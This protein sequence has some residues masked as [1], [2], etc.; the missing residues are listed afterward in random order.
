MGL[1][2]KIHPNSGQQFRLV[3]FSMMPVAREGIR[4]LHV[5]VGIVGGNQNS[6]KLVKHVVTKFIL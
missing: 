5:V 4:V 2:K 6:Y 3:M 1:V